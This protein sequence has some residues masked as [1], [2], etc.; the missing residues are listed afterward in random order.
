MFSNNTIRSFA[1]GAGRLDGSLFPV[2]P[3]QMTCQT[4]QSRQRPDAKDTGQPRAKSLICA[5]M[6]PGN[7]QGQVPLWSVTGLQDRGLDLL[8]RR[9]NAIRRAAPAPSLFSHRPVLYERYRIQLLRQGRQI[10]ATGNYSSSVSLSHVWDMLRYSFPFVFR[11][12]LSFPRKRLSVV[13]PS[14]T[15]LYLFPQAFS[16]IDISVSITIEGSSLS[17]LRNAASVQNAPCAFPE[18][19]QVLCSRQLSRPL[20]IFLP[21]TSNR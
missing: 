16:L 13:A 15:I 1:D 18:P 19:A 10:A 4:C 11:I 6:H 8:H 3:S 20:C 7:S 2:A 12:I 21:P 17:C 9:P 5:L 14:S